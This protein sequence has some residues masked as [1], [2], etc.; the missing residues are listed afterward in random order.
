MLF[1]SRKSKFLRWQRPQYS[2]LVR[3]LEVFSVVT[4]FLFYLGWDKF[5]GNNDSRRRHRRAKWLVRQLLYLGPTFI[6]IGQSLSTRADLLPIEYVQELQQLQDR[7]PPFE[8]AEAIAVIESELGKPIDFLFQEFES[9]PLA[10]ASLGQVHRARLHTGEKVV[11]K[12][13][14]P[15][16]EELFNLD[17]EVLHQLVRAGKRYLPALKKYDLEAIYEEFFELLFLEIDYIHE[18]KNADR[19]QENFKNYARIKVPKV[20]WQYTT[21]K[22]L[23]LE[24][25]P[26][27]KIDDRQSLEAKG[28]NLDEIIQLGICSY[29]KQLLQDGF[30]QSDPHPGNMAVSSSGD[31]IF[32]DFGTMA[33]VKSVAKDQMIETFFAVLRKDT[34]KVV[35]TMIYMGLIEPMRDLTPVKRIVAF[36]LEEFRNKPIDIKAF[37]Q[38]GEE[39]Y[40]MF[41]Q[42]PF[43]LP[44]QMTFII[45]SITT[46]DGIARA[47]DPQYNLLAAS[48]PFVRSLAVSNGKGTLVSALA[49]QVREFIKNKWQ[50]P[51]ATE[52]Y[53]R[54]LEEKIERGDLQLRI[55]SLE[56]ERT[57]KRIYMAI[58]SLI[59]ACLTGLTL[60]SAT[61]LLSTA[62]SKFAIIAFGGAGLFSLFLLRSL[63]ALALQ[64]KLD[65][66]AD[67]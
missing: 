29:L 49:K 31:L 9:T 18:G 37:E 58:K 32:Y 61:V 45:K 33:E 55:R 16:L 44:A 8:I 50:Q 53:L 13:Q 42:Q 66:L 57:L 39:V 40:L 43:R 19:F 56:N 24:Y 59:Y 15:G 30:F 60:L 63:I 34:D 54:R 5:A 25:L 65:K 62:Y 3:Q 38:V 4:Q 64:E 6:K 67:K 51:S 7:V 23:T 35:E 20:Y 21:K 52:R 11:V 14:R 10:S 22:V 48:Q 17:F 1:R 27:I 28:I 2:P 12:V 46:L 26:G 41:K 36:L 47:L